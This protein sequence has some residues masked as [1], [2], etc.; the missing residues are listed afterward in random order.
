MESLLDTLNALPLPPP[1]PQLIFLLQGATS[2]LGPY[3]NDPASLDLKQ[4]ALLLFILYMTLSIV[5]MA[6][7][8][9]MGVFRMMFWIGVAFFSMWVYTVGVE[10]AWEAVVELGHKLFIMGQGWLGGAK[11]QEFNFG[12]QYGEYEGWGQQGKKKW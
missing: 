11:E 7:R 1:F 12:N 6:A 4:L 10:E 8:W 9:V 2:K 5:G 3:L